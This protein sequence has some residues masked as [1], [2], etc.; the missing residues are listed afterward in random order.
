MDWPSTYAKRREGY[1]P[2]SGR[3]LQFEIS[4]PTDAA[5]ARADRLAVPKPVVDLLHANQS[6]VC[7]TGSRVDASGSRSGNGTQ[8]SGSSLTHAAQPHVRLAHSGRRN[9]AESSQPAS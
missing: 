1:L 3:G 9:Q 6:S 7:D 5:S 4:G 2:C 8:V